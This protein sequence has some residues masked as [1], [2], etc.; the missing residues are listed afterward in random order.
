MISLIG[1]K[2]KRNVYG[3][4]SWTDIINDVDIS[5]E[6]HFDIDNCI[7]YQRLNKIYVKGTIHWFPI[8]EIVIIKNEEIFQHYNKE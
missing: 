8:E 5:W 1:L 2:F 3:L 6:I 7:K 4:S